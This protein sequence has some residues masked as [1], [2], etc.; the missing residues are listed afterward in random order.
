NSGSP[1]LECGSLLP[2]WGGR[3]RGRLLQRRHLTRRALIHRDSTTLRA[4]ASLAILLDGFHHALRGGAEERGAIL[5]H[6]FHA[7][8]RVRVG[9]LE[10]RHDVAGDELVA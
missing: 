10:V 5:L 3:G 9:G 2:L 4:F 8:A 1:L 6:P 7:A